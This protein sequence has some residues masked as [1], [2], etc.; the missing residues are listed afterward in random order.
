M[1]AKKMQ[2][3]KTQKKQVQVEAPLPPPGSDKDN[4]DVGI[5]EKQSQ[6]RQRQGKFLIIQLWR[7]IHVYAD[8]V[9][10]QCRIVFW[11]LHLS[12]YG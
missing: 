6:K 9:F 10:S 11:I 4:I 1:P 12:M 8:I 5:V 7:V 3:R 2:Q